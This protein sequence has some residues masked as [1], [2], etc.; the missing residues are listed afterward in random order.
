MATASMCSACVTAWSHSSGE[1]VS[2]RK[3]PLEFTHA[4][5]ELV[6]GKGALVDGRAM[7]AIDAA[8]DA[9]PIGTVLSRRVREAKGTGYR[10]AGLVAARASP[11][12]N[13]QAS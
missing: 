3:T 6:A 1:V 4:A 7:A 13:R 12:V 2:Q 11:N 10:P 9:E 8:R 5:L